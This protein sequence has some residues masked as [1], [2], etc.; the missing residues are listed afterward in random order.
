MRQEWEPVRRKGH[1][2][3]TILIL[4]FVL[5][6]GITIGTLISTGVDA[7]KPAI[8]PLKISSTGG[9]AA[10]PLGMESPAFPMK[11]FSDIAKAV[12]PAVVNINTEM[13]IQNRA[14]GLRGQR[15]STPQQQ[16]PEGMLPFL[17]IPRLFDMPEQRTV[18]SLGSGFIVDPSGYIIT[19]NHV[20]DRATKIKV[21]L[22]NGD[23]YTA[24]VIGTDEL[25]DMAVI[26]IEGKQP[27]PCAKIG[28]SSA[29]SPGDW[30]VAIGSPFGLDQTVTAG[31]I[32]ATGRV[33]QGI[34]IFNDYLQT[35]ASINQG[36]SGGPLLNMSGEVVGINTFIQSPS[37]GSVG[38][39]FAIPS[40]AFLDVYNQLS[41]SGKV[42]RGFLGI[43]M[44][45]VELTPEMAKFFGVQ[46]G[47]GVLITE[48]INEKGEASAEGPAAKAGMKAEDV[49]V[50]ING[51]KVASQQDVR[52]TI[53]TTAPG[54]TVQVK[55]YRKGVL[56]NFQ[57]TLAERTLEQQQSTD[58]GVTL[59]D[60][61]EEPVKPKEIGL[62]VD[63]IT[64][65]I[66]REMR[67]DTSDG[68]IVVD[69]KS[70]SL[71]EEAGLTADDIILELN[72]KVLKGAQS[73]GQQF[74]SLSSGSGAVIKFLRGGTGGQSGRRQT[75]YTSMIKP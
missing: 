20:V 27:F 7:Q 25:T 52:T 9:A 24:K 46:G 14:R 8:E 39:G 68:V 38:M 12:G 67:L 72:G 53:A 17:D 71:A 31:I 73:F 2:L 11:G 13:I 75:L 55:A 10:K 47:K 40:R 5:G 26:K 42:H 58:R 29:V 48:M 66:M 51:R 22:S 50:E 37:G 45:P 62:T 43:S 61:P 32:S 4:L 16:V 19:N 41:T 33:V 6:V 74:R 15:K 59:D 1:R 69:V 63:D 54:K 36:N 34:G 70:D 57:V 35:D 60:Q 30:V 56:Q 44:N 18:H 3:T 65:S 49:I 28:D 21:N 23:E 64:P